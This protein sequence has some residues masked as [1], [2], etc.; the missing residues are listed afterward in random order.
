[1]KYFVFNPLTNKLT[2]AGKD[3]YALGSYE[4]Q[5]NELEES[6]KNIKINVQVSV[7]LNLA[8]YS[9]YVS[10]ENDNKN[11][12]DLTNIDNALLYTK[13]I[14]ITIHNKATALSVEPTNVKT[15]AG[16]GVNITAKLSTGYVG[17][18]ASGSGDIN[19]SD[20][21]L[22]VK[23]L[24]QDVLYYA[25]TAENENAKDLYNKAKADYDT[26]KRKGDRNFSVWDIFDDISITYVK[27]GYGYDY[28]LSFRLKEEY[29]YLSYAGYE[30][31]EWLFKLVVTAS[32]NSTLSREISVAFVPQQLMTFRIENYSNLVARDGK[33]AGTT[34]SEFVSNE[35][36]SSLII[37]GESGLIKIF[38]EYSYSYFDNIKV[39][40]TRE[41]IDGKEY[42]VRFQQMVYDKERNMYVSYAGITSDGSSLTLAPVS[43]FEDGKYVYDGVIFVRTLL[44]NIVGVRKVFTF[45][46][47]AKTYN[48]SGDVIDVSCEKTVISQYRPGVYISVA[49]AVE[50][51][52]GDKVVYMV[53]ENSNT[54]QVI[55]KVYGYEFNIEPRVSLVNMSG[56]VLLSNQAKYE[57]VSATQDGNGAY[58]L[59]YKLRVYSGCPAFKMSMEMELIDGGNKL[60]SKSEV[61]TFYSV[62]YVINN[63]YIQ[64]ESNGSLNINVSTSKDM[65]LV[66]TTQTGTSKTDDINSKILALDEDYLKL[67]HVIGRNQ[68]TALEEKQY[69]T[70]FV[71]SQNTN[72]SIE[73]NLDGKYRIVAIEEKNGIVVYFNLYYGYI[74]TRDLDGNV[75][76]SEIQFSATPT[77]VCNKLISYNFYLNLLKHSTED[78][79][80]EIKTADE[81]R[82]MAQG[83][84]YILTK[85]ITLDGWTPLTT[86]IG[87]LDGN[88]HVITIKSFN[89]LVT[90]E[91]NAG[92]FATISENTIIKNVVI[93]I[94]QLE[95][96]DNVLY[97]QD[98]NVLNANVN[99]GLLAGTNNGLV[100]NCEIISIGRH[101][102]LQIETGASYNVVLGGLIG[103]NNGNITNSR[104]GT[105]YFERITQVTQGKNDV[106]TSY[107]S[108]GKLTFTAK[109]IVAGLV[110]R[111]S[112][113]SIISSSY[114]ANT[115]IL[116]TLANGN[117]AKNRTAGFVA[118]NSGTIAYSYAKGWENTILSTKARA[119]GCKVYSDAGSVAG[120]VYLNSGEIHDCYS[121]IVC[122]SQSAGVAG[123]VYDTTGGAI[124]QSYT[125]STVVA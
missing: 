102:E 124:R 27:Q 8:K 26:N 1:S 38:A 24:N 15:E 43:Y 93:D 44:E 47:D 86:A 109:G 34:E 16:V 4:L 115:S 46:V 59:V 113:G 107:V 18:I 89:I 114:V 77:D 72:F 62:P 42:F 94:S 51:V 103:V 90:S 99:F 7:Y 76:D 40:S 67:F 105:E 6:I 81:L 54:T 71:N 119:T 25:L 120:F 10:A 111:N 2:I 82:N 45:T 36:E 100:Y 88:G 32:T 33:V 63:V 23:D 101:K 48:A 30:S 85:D 19:I 116:N 78:L 61:L 14:T 22:S 108:C 121:N 73:Q 91:I 122:E 12:Y 83:E 29:R 75:I 65:N 112:S 80:A 35:V 9:V 39:S 3:Y 52:D 70:E 57:L 58:N 28:V 123:F 60:T 125:A 96:E 20:E 21:R 37:P 50:S 87:S 56:D 79:P 117:S 118:E 31:K 68:Q 104:V 66:W 5:T 84:N 110:G 69:F 55:A 74:H 97:V 92:L 11:L 17:N 53:E 106:I 41:I 98:L 64:G 95:R 49:N 13:D